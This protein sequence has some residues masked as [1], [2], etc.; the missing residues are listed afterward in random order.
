[1]YAYVEL[2]EPGAD[3][4]YSGGGRGAAKHGEKGGDEQFWAVVIGGYHRLR[5]LHRVLLDLVERH[6]RVIYLH[7]I[8]SNL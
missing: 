3:V 8:I 2:A 7:Y 5:V 4:K 6:R 1:M